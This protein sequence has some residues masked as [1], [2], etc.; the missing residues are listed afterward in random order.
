MQPH[1]TDY[2]KTPYHQSFSAGSQY[3]GAVAPQWVNST[4]LASPGGRILFD[5]GQR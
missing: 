5:E 1:Y 4:Q 3:A 2:W